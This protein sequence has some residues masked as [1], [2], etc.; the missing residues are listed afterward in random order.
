MKMK[1][2]GITLSVLGLSVTA[3]QSATYFSEDFDPAPT[4]YGQQLAD[5][6]SEVARGDWTH[7]IA[8]IT[9][10]GGSNTNVL[11]LATH[12][13]GAT[14]GAGI[15]LA[16]SVFTEGSGTYDLKFEVAGLSNPSQSYL[17]VQV[18][19][20]N[21]GTGHY[22]ID[23]VVAPGDLLRVLKS[24]GAAVSQITNKTSIAATGFYTLSFDYDGSDDVV[25][26][27]GIVASSGVT[28]TIDIDTISVS[29]ATTNQP[30]V[31][32]PDSFEKSDATAGV[33]Y[34]NSI[35]NNASDPDGDVLNF[36][37]ISPASSWL[38]VSNNGIISGT[39]D[40]FDTGTNTFT[41]QV[42]DGNGS[43]TA[44]MTIVV[45][46]DPAMDTGLPP[47]FTN[48]PII[49]TDVIV[50]I[51]YTNSIASEAIDPDGDT[52][53]FS[54][55]T[56]GPDWLNIA[57]D[58]TLTGTP[59]DVGTNTFTVGVS[60]TGG[61]DTATLHIVVEN[62]PVAWN[63]HN[64]SVDFTAAQGYVDGDV[65]TH[66]NWTAM[67]ANLVSTNADGYNSAKGV[68][69]YDTDTAYRDAVYNSYALLADGESITTET[70][71]RFNSTNTGST[72][73]PY[74]LHSHLYS[75]AWN[76][77]ANEIRV[78]FR[79]NKNAPNTFDFQ[80]RAW[81]D[82]N[83]SNYKYSSVISGDGLGLSSGLGQ[84]D[85]LK[86]TTTLTKGANASSWDLNIKLD[87][88]ADS[89]NLLDE[90][91]TGITTQTDFYNAKTVYPGL[92]SGSTDAQCQVAANS[93]EID[94]FESTTDSVELIGEPPAFDSG[95]FFKP[96][97]V[98]GVAYSGSLTNNASDPDGDPLAFALSSSATWLNVSP[99]GAIT[100]TPTAYDAGTNTFT[101]QVSATGGADTATMKI[102]VEPVPADETGWD[103]FVEQ[104]GLRGNK[105]DDTDGDGIVDIEEYAM[106]GN[107]T[108]AV[109]GAVSQPYIEST[110][111]NTL[112]FAHLEPA[113]TNLGITYISEW[114]D[115]L[116]T[117][118]WH[119][120]WEGTN[121]SAST[122][123]PGYE[124]VALQLDITNKDQLFMRSRIL[125]PDRPNILLILMD[126][127][128]YCDVGFMADLFGE[129]RPLSPQTPVI[130]SLATN[131]MVCTQAYIPHPFCGP[132]RMGLLAG[133]YPH[134]FGGSKNLP[135]ETAERPSQE[136]L[137]SEWNADGW[138]E[139]ANETGIHV[140]E[141]TI[142]KVLQ[143]AGY[144][145]AALGKWH[146][147]VADDYH[148]NNR[149]F[150][151][152]YGML[153]GGHNYYSEGWMSRTNPAAV[154]DYQ[155]W[156]TRNDAE[157]DPSVDP[158]PGNHYITDILS[159]D[160]VEVIS[161]APA[162]QPFFMYL[163]YNA[164]HAPMQGKVED[165][166][167]LFGGD[168]DYDNY[169]REQN[170][171]AM[172]A[173]VDRGISNIVATLE[174]KGILDETMIIFFSDNGGKERDAANGENE[175]DNG[176]LTGGKGD[177]Y[178][179]G[180][181]SPMFIHYPNAIASGSIYEH[182]VYP[183]DLYPTFAR[184]GQAG[185]PTAK[186]LSGRDI[187]DEII[188]DQNAH[189]TDPVFW[190][191]HNA[192]ANN[193]SM[194]KGRYKANRL[195]NG[196]WKLYDIISDYTESTDI[197]SGNSA[198][199]DDMIADGLVWTNN[200]V[201]PLWHDTEAGYWNWETNSMPNYDQTFSP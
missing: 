30:P 62:P 20:A 196:S 115:N 59:V 67:V 154:N 16:Q 136:F 60:S 21:A 121:S 38:S 68:L 160:A 82:T 156:L 157:V 200:A 28:D 117:G 8:T 141:T 127:L 73:V 126:D 81:N 85:W 172:M 153:G 83:A 110:E 3:A 189:V 100:G 75:D 80:T 91:F 26:L 184:L 197:A 158:G 40:E 178:E 195:N 102:V 77:D 125:E 90:S 35:T 152:W 65:S 130:D 168:G 191:R 64:V 193:I 104:Y 145:T 69:T 173:A 146:C 46:P 112:S 47:A 176:P 61:V 101:V 187:W 159:D 50:D 180:V 93:R 149:G 162:D 120:A 1:K 179:G 71:F 14:R 165:L 58:G 79:R 27:F 2:I 29:S 10:I 164:P 116:V 57:A 111:S 177:T 22:Q 147:G 188:A 175:A 87:N 129:A 128:G 182:P 37:L 139:K 43:D 118:V 54:K 18:W 15:A 183:Y 44:T 133:R 52:L 123:L 163:C 107:P 89:T 11:R 34:S 119:T 19:D 96:N 45:N 190:V 166:I 17:D 138:Y 144:Y 97:A 170:G 88:L 137:D 131:G 39:P 24:T 143:D 134:H 109:D 78:M 161:S 103:E 4:L 106:G 122:T 124:D 72:A 51:A 99:S 135:Y 171:I 92:T 167:A 31:F 53:T 95:S 185:I 98:V 33:S 5:I 150:D 194:R 42:S 56:G 23:T 155:H 199:I 181:R 86:L 151:Y 25:L 108:S 49:R 41:I 48:T 105:Y 94:R 132:S 169:T 140:D 6:P 55:R 63:D 201:D 113:H 148:P 198:I 76:I 9:D 66:S 174:T 70:T 32:S 114:T 84:S 12:S 142:A 192:G 13:N 7:W 74:I 186:V 36:S